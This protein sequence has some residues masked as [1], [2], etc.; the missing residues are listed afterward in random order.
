MAEDEIKKEIAALEA[1]LKTVDVQLMQKA[2]AIMN[3]K[4]AG[5]DD[6]DD[7]GGDGVMGDENY[8]E[9][10]GAPTD[11]TKRSGEGK[12]KAATMG[13]GGA[14]AAPDEGEE[15]QYARAEVR[16][17]P[18]NAL[19]RLNLASALED[20]RQFR[21]AF[22][23]ARAATTLTKTYG[24]AWKARARL[25]LALD[26]ASI[27][28][29]DADE[30]WRETPLDDDD[31]DAAPAA[32]RAASAAE[33]A[34]LAAA[35]KSAGNGHF[36]AKRMPEAVE[37]WTEAVDHLKAWGLAADAKL[38]SNRAAAYLQLGKNVLAATDARAS[39]DA[40]ATWWKAHWYLGQALSAQLAHSANQRGACTSNGERAQE[41][42]RAINTC[43][44]CASLPADKTEEVL[45]YKEKMQAKIYEMTDQGAC[46]VM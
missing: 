5:P 29:Q 4:A 38:Y 3:A 20:A 31:D 23:E 30:M 15:L 17:C 13:G 43:S 22:A 46:S 24:R 6:D 25:E 40:D 2:D 34:Q 21:A 1:Q 7:G 35:C 8:D 41:A 28:R 37:A 44:E 16:A 39:A 32:P 45:A 26:E 36:V 9:P 33:A 11:A 19:C 10:D 18:R 12:R 42:Y 14:K 27:D